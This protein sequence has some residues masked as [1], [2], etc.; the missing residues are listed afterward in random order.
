[1][2]DESLPGL[3]WHDKYKGGISV[4]SRLLFI[5]LIISCKSFLSAE[6]TKAQFWA[7]SLAG[8][9]TEMNEYNRNTLNMGEITDFNKR[10]WLETLRRDWG[11]T[12]REELLKTLDTTENLGHASSLRQM[13]Q[14]I[15]EMANQGFSIFDIYNKYELAD[16]Q[17][18]RLKFT[19]ANW[20]MLRNRTLM[21]WDIGRCISLC[22]WGYS[23]GFLEEE[24]AWEKI[25]YYAKKL[26]LF[27]NSWREYGTD[28]LWGR[29]F[30]GSGSGED[31]TY[32]L[33]TVPLYNRLTTA[34]WNNIDWY[35]N[36]SMEARDTGKTAAQTIRYQKPEDND[37]VLQFRTND[38]SNYNR[39]QP[40]YMENPGTD[41]DIIQCSVKKMSGDDNYGF[42]ILFCVNDSAMSKR[43]FY[44]LFITVR[45]TFTVQKM[46]DDEWLTPPIRWRDS[47]FLEKGY[48]VYNH[49]MVERTVDNGTVTF[50]VFFNKNLAATFVD[51]EPLNGV[52]V[53]LVTS[54]NVLGKEMFPHIPVDVRFDY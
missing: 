22:R 47:S 13:K 39:W 5:V 17:Y 36:L 24:E 30:F 49:I 26:Q 48:N 4:R 41:K 14:I 35:T 45:G 10:G 33:R 46:I 18:N 25:M 16:Y 27:Y 51:D 6:L 31:I 28:Y 9:M 3:I 34:F 1:L 7:I 42:G 21:A 12:N 37:G 20:N 32:L 52:R 44:R 23:V 29:L 43:S 50:N 53:G 2:P 19:I 54:V 38:P 40:F 15:N 8:M 11:V